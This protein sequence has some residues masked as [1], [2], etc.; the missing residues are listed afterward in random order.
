MR[1]LLL[2]V[3]AGLLLSGLT[4]PLPASADE[5]EDFY[6]GK[7]I[8]LY[9]GYR[10]GGGYDRYSRT[11]ARHLGRHIPGTPRIIVKNRPGAGSLLLAN[12]VYKGLRQD[13]TAIGNV[14][15]AIPTEPLFGNAEAK[16]DG[17]GFT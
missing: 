10:A 1:N 9:V 3:G 4:A 2:T 16:F 15:R 6:K 7:E 12:G 14:G 11:L 8:T 13:G 17:R 5:I